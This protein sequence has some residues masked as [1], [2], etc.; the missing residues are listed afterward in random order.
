MRTKMFWLV[1]LAWLLLVA[2]ASAFYD[3][4]LQR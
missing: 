2:N 1:G 4:G 3:P